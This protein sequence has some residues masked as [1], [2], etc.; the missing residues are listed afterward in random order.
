MNTFENEYTPNDIAYGLIVSAGP[1]NVTADIESKLLDF[2]Y[3]LLA[4]A[5]NEYNADYFRTAYRAFEAISERV[6]R[7]EIRP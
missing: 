6:D 1:E 4:A 2:A 7:G 5:Q 3:W